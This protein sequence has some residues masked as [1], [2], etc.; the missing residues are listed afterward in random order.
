[1]KAGI[2]ARYSTG[3]QDHATIEVQVEE[4]AKYAEANSIEIYDVFA[5]EAVS[6][7]KVQRPDFQRL[8]FAADRKLFDAVIIYDQSRFS[9][10]LVDWFLFR[11][12]MEANGIKILSVTQPM[13]GGDLNDPSVFASEGINALFNQMHVLQTREKVNSAMKHIAM[14]GLH[15]GG[16]PLL[17][18]DVVD[19]K[20]AVNEREAEIVRTIFSMYANDHSYR[21]IIA[22]LNQKGYRTK[23]GKPFGVNSL[24]SLLR[25]ER[26]IGTYI[27][28]KIPPRN[29]E[30]K[31]N[32]H[33]T[34]SEVIR[35]EGAIPRIIS[36]ETWKAVQKRLSNKKMNARYQREESYLLTGKLVCGECGS[37]LVGIRS[38]YTYYYYGCS[39]KQR[40]GDCRKS[41]L[42]MQE[43][44][45]LVVTAVRGVLSTE[46][47]RSEVAKE[48][49]AQQEKLRHA[50]NP[51]VRQIKDKLKEVDKKIDNINRAITEG[52]WGASTASV[53]KQLEEER[54]GLYQAMASAEKTRVITE[55]TVQEIQQVLSTIYDLNVERMETRKLL[56]Q[57]IDS[58]VVCQDKIRIIANPLQ[59]EIP[60][61]NNLLST[62]TITTGAADLAPFV[63]VQDLRL[64]IVKYL[65]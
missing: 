19:K 5:D 36:D 37:S 55:H 3:N 45:D 8:L 50:V 63:S 32:S 53:L 54:A 60:V 40:R 64:F 12:N 15:T 34:S 58:V 51:A 48:L 18:Y 14:Q 56:V 2:Y 44:D 43:L 20:Y 26:Y 24:S 22:A 9:R 31:R 1:M 11:R 46:L 52:I 21:S 41:N 16:R 42:K 27:Y 6:G 28:K 35:L 49:F 38:K 33:A 25:N 65:L 57:F 23:A 17:G 29:A 61:D 4:C 59:I 30:G 13:V 62:G 7:M 47:K 39:A 10:D